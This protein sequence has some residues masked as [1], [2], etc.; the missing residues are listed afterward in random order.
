MMARDCDPAVPVRLEVF[1]NILIVNV[2]EGKDKP[3][4]C[5]TGFY[6]RNGSSSV[7]LSTHEIREF[8]QDEGLIR[9][10]DLRVRDMK[11]PNDLNEA[12]LKRFIQLS[13]ISELIGQTQILINL[14]VLKNNKDV[15]FFNNAG[16]LFFGNCLERFLPH[17]AISCVLFK[18]NKKVHIIDR[19]I[20]EFDVLTNIDQAVAF[21]ERHINLLYEI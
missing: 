11:F 1:E 18:G 14:K 2:S 13:K 3:Y 4:R 16:A 9:F 17:A 12:A 8:F 5:S 10:E 6:L 21:V 15:A 7:K 19:K 20:L